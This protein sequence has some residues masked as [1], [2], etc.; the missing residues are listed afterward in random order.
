M[1]LKEFR[2]EIDKIDEGIINLLIERFDV[3]EQIMFLKSEIEDKD[4]ESK[5][6]EKVHILTKK[7]KNQDFFTKLYQMIFEES[8]K[9]GI[10][11]KANNRRDDQS[12][13]LTTGEQKN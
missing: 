3:V 2:D 8:K 6:I 11:H 7:T 9:R 4:R 5:I 13:Y 1:K 12:G 10:I